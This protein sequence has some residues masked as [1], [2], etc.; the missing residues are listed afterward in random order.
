M[1][2]CVLPIRISNILHNILQRQLCSYWVRLQLHCAATGNFNTHLVSVRKRSSAERQWGFQ[3]PSAN[4]PQ[5]CVQKLTQNHSAE[6]FAS[7]LTFQLTRHATQP[8]DRIRERDKQNISDYFG[9]YSLAFYPSA[10]IHECCADRTIRGVHWPP[11]GGSSAMYASAGDLLYTHGFSSEG[12]FL[13]WRRGACRSPGAPPRR[14]PR[15][16]SRTRW[17][18]SRCP[19]SC[20][21]RPPRPA[22]RHRRSSRR[23]LCGDKLRSGRTNV[24]WKLIP[25]LE[26]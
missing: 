14:W 9:K 17:S 26:E 13:S 20:C 21:H 12:A 11:E 22:R 23:G 1:C 6:L 18:S 7:Q 4:P 24:R 16:S 10:L 5:S 3:N 2:L 25:Y 19:A 8:C 15:R